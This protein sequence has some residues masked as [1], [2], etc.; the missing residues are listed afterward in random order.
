MT[1]VCTFCIC[2]GAHV[3]AHMQSKCPKYLTRDSLRKH[4]YSNIY[5]NSP[6]KT[7]FS[8]K[9]KTDIFHTSAQN[10]VGTR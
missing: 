1:S 3:E 9:K 4:T 8:D 6:P 5:K 10:I 7:E 2:S